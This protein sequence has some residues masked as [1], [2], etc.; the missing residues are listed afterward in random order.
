MQLIM[1]IGSNVLDAIP[2]N[3]D[4]LHLPEYV[5]CLQHELLM[6]NE[7][8]LEHANGDVHFAL[9]QVPSRQPFQS[10]LNNL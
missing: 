1:L 5:T 6:R 7:E 9:D 3:P 4:K 10:L 2:I 8:R